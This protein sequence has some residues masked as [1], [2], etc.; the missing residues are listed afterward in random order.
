MVCSLCHSALADKEEVPSTNGS[1]ETV[2]QYRYSS[3]SPDEVALINGAEN[4][5]FTFENRTT[6]TLELF[7]HYTN[8]QEVWEVLAE[9][10]FDSDRKR[11]TMVL[12]NRD[13]PEDTVYVLSK[14]ADNIMLPLLNID[15]EEA[16]KTSGKF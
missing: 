13:D 14:G 3:N 2:T 16:D 7:N 12:K 11:M 6:N 1:N 8:S 5:G 9:I 15:K 4:M 10:P